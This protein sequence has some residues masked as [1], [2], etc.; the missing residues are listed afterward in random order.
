MLYS[1]YSYTTTKAK[2]EIMKKIILCAVM[3]IS[4]LFLSSVEQ[5]LAQNYPNKAIKFIVPWTPGGSNDVL[6]RMVGQKLQEA[7]GQPVVIENRP[8][9]SGNIGTVLVKN[10]APDGYTLLIAANTSKPQF[11]P[12]ND[13]EPVALLGD[14]PVLL[15]INPSVPAKS[16]KELVALAKAKPGSLTYGSSGI[17]APQHL[18]AELF[19]MTAGIDMVHVTYKGA[20]QTIPDLLSGQI[21]VL[22]CAIN[23]IM[24]HVKSGGV[25]ALAAAEPKRVPAFP[26]LPTI[27]ESGVRG[28][29]AGIWISLVAPKGTPKN[30]VNK[31]N[32]EIQKILSDPEIINKIRVQGMEPALGTP[33]DLTKVIRTDFDRWAKVIKALNL[34]VD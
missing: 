34:R 1:V 8:G 3:L 9:A 24:P 12:F 19:K 6:A 5:A 20:A 18:S 33:A 22:F 4:L 21:Q 14:V 2:G 28:V 7:W 15:V 25:R 27:D 11:D 17:G 30:I 31:M 29:Y 13:F 10:A 26:D 16:V 23:S 32:S